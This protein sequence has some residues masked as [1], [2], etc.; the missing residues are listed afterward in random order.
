MNPIKRWLDKRKYYNTKEVFKLT[1]NEAY[2][3]LGSVRGHEN[4]IRRL[5]RTIESLRSCLS[6]NAIRYDID[7]VDSTPKNAMEE[8]FARIDECEKELEREKM[9]RARAVLDIDEAISKLPEGR[10][11]LVL[12]EFYIGKISMPDIADGLG[13]TLRHCFRIRKNAI[14]M[15]VEVFDK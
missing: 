9:Y 14:E 7:R 11:K 10:E 3:F 6:P 13:I 5:E 1:T 4:K 12:T 15:F 2:T 8:L